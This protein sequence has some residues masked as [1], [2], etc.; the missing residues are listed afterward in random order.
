MPRANS[1]RA[2]VGFVPLILFDS[3]WLLATRD[4]L[5]DEDFNLNAPV[6]G[7]RASGERGRAPLAPRH[8]LF[9]NKRKTVLT[10]RSATSSVQGQGCGM[11]GDRNHDAGQH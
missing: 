9:T 7:Y 8:S 10:L 5:V 2:L 11:D 6:L 3:F 4:A 1:L